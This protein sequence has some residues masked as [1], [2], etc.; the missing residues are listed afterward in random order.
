[1]N[2]I[3]LEAI[4]SGNR[5]VQSRAYEA[6]LEASRVPVDWAYTV[7]D[8]LVM[9]LKHKD[10]LVR[11]IAAQVLCNLAQSDPEQRMLRDFDVLLAVTKDERFVT[12]RH[13]LQA[14]WKVG[15][16]GPAQ[17]Q[18]LLAGLAGRFAE[19]PAE[20]NGSLTRFDILQSL[21][22]LYDQTQDESIR[23]LALELIESETD[24]KNRK[25][26]AGLWKPARR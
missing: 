14:I 10:N 25:K 4:L 5:E 17:R 8:P 22:N 9:A 6:A 26:C 16:A 13:C 24:L 15:L 20:K 19:C 23:T 3:D 2:E 7:W 12:A 21:R 18:K 11:A 1:M